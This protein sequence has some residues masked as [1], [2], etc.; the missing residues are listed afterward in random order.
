MKFVVGKAVLFVKLAHSL[1]LVQIVDCRQIMNTVAHR[2]DWV[3]FIHYW[4]SL[5]ASQ[6]L[7]LLIPFFI[8]SHGLLSEK[9]GIDQVFGFDIFADKSFQR[10]DELIDWNG[11][12]ESFSVVFSDHGG[13]PILHWKVT[14]DILWLRR[15]HHFVRGWVVLNWCIVN[16]IAPWER[17]ASVT[18][19]IHNG[20][21]CC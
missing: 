2:F 19:I 12:L 14:N 16:I 5:V 8:D 18:L 15:L 7:R 1:E 11:F 9:H 17:N 6:I 13:R 3:E 10:C 20:L 4:W 21:K